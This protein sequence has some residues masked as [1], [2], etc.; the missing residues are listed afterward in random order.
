MREL[1]RLGVPD[2]ALA[3]LRQRRFRGP[4]LVATGRAWRLGVLLLSR[5]GSLHQ[6]TVVTRAVE[7]LRGVT[8]RSA[9]AEARR[10]LRRVAAHSG[11]REGEAVNVD[12][13]PIA[14]DA[15]GEVRVRWNPSAEPV[16]LGSYLAERIALL[17]EGVQ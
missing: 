17:G 2:E 4:R 14:P 9:E 5:D 6:T 7:P 12:P 13:V 1:E 10:D 16:L 11:F 15:D 8:N 3:I